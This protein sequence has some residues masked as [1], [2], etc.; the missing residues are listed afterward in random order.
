MTFWRD[1]E[2]RLLFARSSTQF[3][4]TPLGVKGT[5]DRTGSANSATVHLRLVL[6]PIF[7]IVVALTIGV[8]VVLLEALSGHDGATSPSVLAVVLSAVIV[9]A[10]VLSF[11]LIQRRALLDLQHVISVLRCDEHSLCDRSSQNA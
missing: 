7:A 2:D 4:W 11:R 10:G 5:I 6:G 8:S 1:G 3:G 9:A